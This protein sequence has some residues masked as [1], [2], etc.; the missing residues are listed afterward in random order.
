R[1]R[2]STGRRR[3][4]RIALLLSGI[5][6]FLFAVPAAAQPMDHSM[7]GSQPAAKLAPEV[8][9]CTPEH[10]AMGHCTLDSAPAEEAPAPDMKAMDHGALAA[11]PACPP[12]HAAMGHCTPKPAEEAGQAGGTGT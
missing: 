7:H 11:D 1:Q 10:A 12:E 5:A 9:A 8:P 4:T 6:P 2:P 3:M